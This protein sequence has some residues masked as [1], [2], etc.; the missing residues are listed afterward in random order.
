MNIIAAL[1]A[2]SSRWVRCNHEVEV[3]NYEEPQIEAMLVR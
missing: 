2:R 3:Q 1:C